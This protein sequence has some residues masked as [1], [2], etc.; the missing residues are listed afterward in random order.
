M[1]VEDW[2]PAAARRTALDRKLKA[3]EVLFRLGSKTVGLYEV[4]T[5]RVRLAR[6]DRLGHEIV[7]HVAGRGEMLAEASLF[8]AQYHC[9]AIA[10]T[11]ATVRLYP[12]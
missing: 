9:D 8:S 4:I 7:L 3:G 5:G 11:N 6:V 2:I 1:S 12:K 10:S